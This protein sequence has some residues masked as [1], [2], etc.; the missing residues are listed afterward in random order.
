MR[1]TETESDAAFAYAVPRSGLCAGQPPEDDEP[2]RTDR[3]HLTITAKTS[4]A[5]TAQQPHLASTG[6]AIRR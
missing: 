1:S 6:A 3:V 4:P 5:P 2:R